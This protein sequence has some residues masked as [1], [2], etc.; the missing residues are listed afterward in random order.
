ML[1]WVAL[2]SACATRT[3]DLGENRQPVAEEAGVVS[4]PQEGG[5][6]FL[7]CVTWNEAAITQRRGPSCA[8]SS[9]RTCERAQGDQAYAVRN[10]EDVVA[11]TAGRWLF[12]ENSIIPSIGTGGPVGPPVVGIEFAPGCRSYA[13][14]RDDDGNL[15]RGTQSVDQGRYDIIVEPGKRPALIFYPNE[16]FT[17][18]MRLEID[19]GQCPNNYLRLEGDPG[20]RPTTLR[21]ATEGLAR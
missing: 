10:A 7:G 5:T 16:G 12:C 4:P 1:S 17:T 14:V 2:A 8:A 18:G 21:P 11:L 6:S 3:F 15:A 19:S 9:S 20:S 13:L